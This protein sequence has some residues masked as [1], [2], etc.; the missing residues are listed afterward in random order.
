M[1]LDWASQM[2]IRNCIKRHRFVTCCLVVH[3]KAIHPSL[4]DPS[5]KLQILQIVQNGK[6]V[7]GHIY[8]MYP[9]FRSCFVTVQLVPNNSK[10][11][12]QGVLG[13]TLE[14]IKDFVFQWSV[15]N[16]NS[17][18]FPSIIELMNNKKLRYFYKNIYF[19]Y[20]LNFFLQTILYVPH[21]NLCL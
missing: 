19:I 12:S 15:N 1:V 20:F 3:L 16:G 13:G 8:N 6:I 14:A 5:V 4:G 11:K 17:N 10:I 2:C 18:H 9:F 21:F 7:K